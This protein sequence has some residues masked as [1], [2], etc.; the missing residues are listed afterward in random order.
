MKT[1]TR[2]FIG[3][4]GLTFLVLI[5]A[6]FMTAGC[7]AWLMKPSSEAGSQQ[8]DPLEGW[9]VD[10]DHEPDQIIVKDYQDYIQTLPP[11]EKKYAHADHFLEDGTGQH[12]ITI[13]IDLNGIEWTHVLIYGVNGKRIKSTKYVSGHYRS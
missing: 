12:A 6:L 8:P 3:R 13:G 2:H 7:G 11:E 1:P 9:K 10:L 4:F 5:A